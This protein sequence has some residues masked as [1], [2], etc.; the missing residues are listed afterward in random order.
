[1]L[2]HRSPLLLYAGEQYHQTDTVTTL[3]SNV[4]I[5]LYFCCSNGIQ[6]TFTV[7]AALGFNIIVRQSHSVMLVTM[8]SWLGRHCCLQYEVC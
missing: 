3:T 4:Q 8:S 7:V 1:M 6:M 5:D 2:Y